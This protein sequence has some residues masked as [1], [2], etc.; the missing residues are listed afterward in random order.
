MCADNFQ[1]GV[2]GRSATYLRLIR[3]S[4]T[5]NGGWKTRVR[6]RIGEQTNEVQHIHPPPPPPPPSPHIHGTLVGSGSSLYHFSNSV[7]VNRSLH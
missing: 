4:L 6:A 3:S 5:G 7:G 2:W 1:Q